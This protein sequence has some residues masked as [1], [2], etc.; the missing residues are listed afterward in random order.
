MRRIDI[1]GSNYHGK[2]NNIREACRGVIVK[3]GKILLSY[4]K[5]RDFWMTP[6]GGRENNE[7]LEECCARE[8]AEETGHKVKVK[9]EF[10]K[11]YEY[12][13]DWRF[14]NHYFICEVIGETQNNLTEAEIENGLEP[15]WID[16]DKVVKIFGT[17]NEYVGKEEGKRGAYLRETN[18]IAQYY[19]TE[20]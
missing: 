10:V 19:K 9:N 1:I 2:Y 13:Q 8:I 7:T 15:R 3:D 20:R 18:A 11:V 4:E 16:F 5:N 6:G 12:Y 17:Y 14:I